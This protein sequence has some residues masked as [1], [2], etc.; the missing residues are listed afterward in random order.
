MKLLTIMT[1]ATLALGGCS[2][3]AQLY[4]VPAPVVDEKIR[5]SVRSV[6][7]RDVS[8][9][10]YAAAEEIHIQMPDGSLTSSNSALWAD[11]PVR[12]LSLELSRNL[13]ELTGAQIAAEP[14]PFER[15]PQARLEVRLEELLAGADGVFRASG[16]YFVAGYEGVRDRSGFFRLTAP[17]DPEAGPAAIAN[18]RGDIVLQLARLIAKEGLR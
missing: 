10:S 12:A 13:A 3:T 17:F 4:S 18:A 11:L 9:P 5:T 6:E 15:F 7:V 14:W 16:Q 8:L 2:G 1:F